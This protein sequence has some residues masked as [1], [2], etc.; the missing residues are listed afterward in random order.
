MLFALDVG[1][2]EQQ[3]ATYT[4]GRAC[5]ERLD[6]LESK[7]LDKELATKANKDNNDK[8]KAKLDEHEFKLNILAK[9][10]IDVSQQVDHFR[11][12]AGLA[13]NP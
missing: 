6:H 4:L 11:K 13:A 2:G 3:D 8:I 7:S 9:V 5:G 10:L 1:L 12:Q